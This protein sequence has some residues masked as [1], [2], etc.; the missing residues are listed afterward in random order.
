MLKAIR[1]YEQAIAKD[2]GYALAWCGMA[3]AYNHLAMFGM[4]PSNVACKKAVTTPPARSR[5]LR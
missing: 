3:D 2:P 5:R 1:Y 4:L